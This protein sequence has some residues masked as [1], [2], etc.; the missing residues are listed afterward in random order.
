MNE[1]RLECIVRYRYGIESM[2]G[3]LISIRNQ[4]ED[5]CSY[6]KTNRSSKAHNVHKRKDQSRI[7]TA[8]IHITLIQHYATRKFGYL[9]AFE[10]RPALLKLLA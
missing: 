7:L 8:N 2:H 6:Q 10:S 1:G 4:A 5:S 3:F 9:G